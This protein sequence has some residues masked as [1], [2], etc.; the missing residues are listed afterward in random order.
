MGQFEYAMVL[1]SI[2]IGLGVTHILS[3]FGSAVHRLRGHGRPIV[4][5]ATYLFWAGLVLQWLV[6]IWWAE[7]KLQEVGVEWTFGLYFFVVWYAIALYFLAVV[8]VPRD[9]EG[10]EDSFDYFMGG[11]RWFFGVFLVVVALDV[12]D[13]FIKGTDWGSRPEYLLL[14]GLWLAA[15]AVGMFARRRSVQ[16]AN[17]IVVFSVTVLWVSSQLGVLGAF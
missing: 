5:E 9:M 12:V 16:R 1:V 7:F 13:T 14:V 15:A 2:I 17:A 4:L 3:A 8:L 6:T 11:R 10:V